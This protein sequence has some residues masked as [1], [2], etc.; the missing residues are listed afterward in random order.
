MFLHKTPLCFLFI[1]CFLAN[2]SQRKA[3]TEDGQAILVYD[4]GT[5]KSA[6]EIE[7]LKNN[8]NSRE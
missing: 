8:D 2:Y 4:N 6:A 5:W 1:S 7:A 3:T